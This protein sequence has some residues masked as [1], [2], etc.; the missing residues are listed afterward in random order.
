M[1]KFYRE[2]KVEL[3]Y[4]TS[5]Y[6]YDCWDQEPYLNK[7]LQLYEDYIDLHIIMAPCPSGIEDLKVS[8]LPVKAF[9]VFSATY[10]GRSLSFLKLLR[11]AIFDE[12]ADLSCQESLED[13]IQGFGER[14][15]EILERSVSDEGQNRIEEDRK[16]AQRFEIK[17]LPSFALVQQ[18]RRALVSGRL[19]E[20]VLEDKLQ[21]ILGFKP[22]A[23]KIRELGEE[24]RQSY[25]LYPR[26][27]KLLYDLEED[28]L[29]DYVEEKLKPE[30]YRWVDYEGG[31][32]L[33]VNHEKL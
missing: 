19:E 3:F 22:E 18:G 12:K 33:E 4:F 5:P 27:L 8:S 17:T 9:R 31:F 1:N 2:Q 30:D 21:E 6:C 14:A 7:F 11:S 29:L 15:G 25:R 23:G 28:Q 32:Y 13:L 10:P 16:L 26:D 20:E 24:L